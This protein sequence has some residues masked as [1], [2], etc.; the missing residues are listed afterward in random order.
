MNREIHVRFSEGVGVKFP[1]ATR[2]H[3]NA[4][5]NAFIKAIM[6]QSGR[7]IKDYIILPNA[8]QITFPESWGSRTNL[9]RLP[10]R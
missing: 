4:V 6:G 5:K 8:S 2:L 7:D 3:S 1:C 9:A 10:R